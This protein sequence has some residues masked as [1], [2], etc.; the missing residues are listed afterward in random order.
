M[1]LL[2]AAVGTPTGAVVTPRLPVNG[3]T[4]VPGDDVQMAFVNGSG[5]SVTVTITAVQ[6]CS[7]GSLHNSV[8]VVAAG[9]TSVIGP[10]DKRYA[11]TVG[12]LATVNYTGIL[13]ST[14]AYTTRV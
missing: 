2:P 6:P 11:A 9:T 12:G 3:D 7:Q 1:A 13:T 8:T 4:I 10:V 5:G 14:T